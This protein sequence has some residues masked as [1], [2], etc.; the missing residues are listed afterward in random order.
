MR[1]LNQGPE[2]HINYNEPPEANA[3]TLSEHQRPQSANAVLQEEVAAKRGRG[4]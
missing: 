1:W 4:R 3:R 2:F